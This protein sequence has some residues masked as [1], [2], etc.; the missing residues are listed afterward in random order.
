MES[1]AAHYRLLLGLDESW[2]VSDVDL[3]VAA[4]RVS[5]ELLFVG[6]QVCCP[7]CGEA[8]ALK[9]HA[10]QR[11]WRHLDTMQFETRLTARVPRSECSACGVKTI[12]V[13]WAD[14][15]SRFTLLFE[16]F[17]IDVLQCSRSVSAGA[18]LLGLGWDAVHGIMQRAVQRGLS[19]REL[20]ELQT[21]GI[22]EKSFGRGQDY[23]SVMT[24]SEES[25]VLE[26]VP[27]RTEEAANELWKC[28]SAEQ[29]QQIKAVSIDMWQA[30]ENS[31]LAHAPQAK[32]VYD[33]FHIAKHLNE[34]VDQV[35]RAENKTLKQEGDER[36]VGSKYLWLTTPTHLNDARAER[37]AALQK[38]Q[39]KTSRAW[40]LKDYFQW[41][42][43]EED[44][45]SGKA[46]FDH[47]YG[48]AIRSRL[49][50]I[51]KVAKMLKGRLKNILTWFEHRITNATSEGFN[52]RIQ[53]I[54][55]NA[56]GFQNFDNYRNR[57]LFF[58][59][60]LSLKPK[61]PTH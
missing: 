15:H 47:W 32:I 4:K 39:L 7:E 6:Q 10:P 43:L 57:I 58:C 5:I 30:F 40:G 45:G 12:Q 52:S 3:D 22:D 42:W 51:K 31:V 28:L 44:S 9:D 35:R 59:G 60:K 34:A 33:K 54:K 55:S 46:F 56:R 18:A 27:G 48:W 11:T 53:N 16:A 24:D 23:V 20:D 2:K 29:K 38:Q 25:R 37:F 8:C 50:P 13:P 61:I 49:E 21:L 19:T 36:L 41:F 14:R 26:V 1:L 17:A